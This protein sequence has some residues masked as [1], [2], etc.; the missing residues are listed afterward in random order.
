MSDQLN[1]V[2]TGGGTAGHVI[3]SKPII[4]A[5]LARGD[6]VTYIGSHS[7]LERDLIAD[8]DVEF[9]AV[10]TGKLRRYFSFANLIDLMRV[11]I[12]ILQAFLF[13]AKLGADV[14]F[15][16]GG[17]VSVPV[18]IAAWLARIPVV[19]HESDLTP[20]LATRLC[21]PL[22]ASQCIN[23]DETSTDA[24]RVVV[25]GTPVRSDLLNGNADRAKDWLGIDASLPVMVVVGGSL[26]AEKINETIR[27]ALDELTE[28]AFVVH[29][30]GA[31]KAQSGL[32]GKSNYR[33]LEFIDKEWG[34]VL[35]LADIVVSRAGANSL[36]EL[37]SL[38][39]PN[40][41]IPLPISA[42]RGD[43]IENAELAESHGWSMVLPQEKLTVQ[44]LLSAVSLLL[45]N[46]E[47]WR[48]KLADF[49]S[50]NSL[51]LLLAEIDR[52]V[53]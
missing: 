48:T 39:V 24:R 7:R 45:D 23:F 3:P 31:G 50:R 27:L 41:L 15:S 29:V 49:P 4:A 38:R 35:A 20:G 44:S 9:H 13:L 16:K 28:R 1:V 51:E 40:L 11:P 36:Y 46:I 2:F 22:V 52:A 42:S 26:G 12:G 47:F 18:V 5:L 19:A 14:V 37:L 17:Y 30:C 21:A 34:D 43:Q 6:R 32:E 25:T 10:T 8:L 53:A 33:Q